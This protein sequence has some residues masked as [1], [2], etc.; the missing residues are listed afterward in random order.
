M[1]NHTVI[2]VNNKG[3]INA[4]DLHLLFTKT[5]HRFKIMKEKNVVRNEE[6]MIVIEEMGFSYTGNAPY[7]LNNINLE[8]K[9]GE[10]ISILG[11]N[12]CGKTTLMRLMLGFMK[13]SRGGISIAT[14]KIGYV[15]QKREQNYSGFP[16]TVYEA[17][18]SY[19]RLLKIKD[20]ACITK[21]LQLV[22]MEQYRDELLGTL[23]GGQTQKI[24]LA[25]AI[26]G[27]PELLLLDEPSTGVD[28]DSQREIYGILKKMNVE[29]GITIVAVEH[30]LDAVYANS[31][32]IY[33]LHHGHGHLCS[34]EKY[35]EE[36][37][38]MPE[39]GERNASI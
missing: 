18:K 17:M 31:T 24:L 32:K 14:S 36:Y 30:N 25:R 13:P 9:S 6:S 16:I 26:M 37:L 7:V 35:A 33:H 1:I 38:H 23:S 34:L 21:A 4:N 19:G 5:L 28:I 39:R 27:E 2:K 8:I 22:G 20:L 10:Y 15:S 12:G 11:D 3:K 29:K